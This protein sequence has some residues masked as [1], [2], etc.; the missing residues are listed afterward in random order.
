VEV[1]RLG[2]GK[3]IEEVE[4]MEY[5]DFLYYVQYINIEARKLNEQYNK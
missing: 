5:G 2:I 1:A 3:T 4:R